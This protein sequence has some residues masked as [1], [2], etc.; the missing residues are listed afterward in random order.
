[1][2]RVVGC[3]VYAGEP[4]MSLSD[5]IMWT[6]DKADVD[7]ITVFHITEFIKDLKT[8]SKKGLEGYIGVGHIDDIVELA[9][10]GL[11]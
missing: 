5:K 9:G 3:C 6:G 1:M 11:I 2:G 4:S 8:K 10:E 7:V